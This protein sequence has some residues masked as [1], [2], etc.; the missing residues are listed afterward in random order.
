LRN[1][2]RVARPRIISLLLAL[3]TLVIYLPAGQHYFIGFDDPD[4]VTENRVVQTGLSGR[5]LEWA[6]TTFHASNWH[7]V[8]WLS[9]MLDC[10][11]FGLN[12]GAHHI[13]S[14]LIHAVNAVLLFTLLLQL[15]G[16][17]WPAAVVAALFAWHPLRVESV[18]WVA[19]RKDVLSLCLGLLCLLAYTKHA[20][21]SSNASRTTD[22]G[23]RTTGFYWLALGFFALGL[24]AKPMLVTLPFVMMLLDWWPLRRVT[25]DRWQVTRNT[26][27]RLLL[28]KLPFFLLMVV[29]C[30]LTYLAQRSQ[31]VVAL[32]NFPLPL[33][34]ENALVSYGGYLLKT[35]WPVNLAII[36]PLPKEIALIKVVVDG[37]ILAL[38]TFLA[39]QWR[40]QKP[41]LLV[42]WLW[43]LGTLVPVIGIVQVG[44]QAMADRYTYLPQIG[45]LIA[46]VFELS[47]WAERS[48]T[49]KRAVTGLVVVASLAC[50]AATA[51]QLSFWLNSET[52]FTH[53]LAVTRDNPVALINL[54]V[55]LEQQGRLGEARTQYETAARLD[56]NRVQTQI[57]LANVM[58]EMGETQAALEHYRMALLLRPN[59]ALAHLNLGSALVKLGRFDEAKLQYETA[60][61][62]L[63][64]DPRPLYLMGKASLRQGRSQEA[65]RQFS[66]ALQL[67][68]NHLQTL[69]WL[70]RTR[71]GDDD[72]WARD[73]VEAVNLAERAAT[74]SGGNDPFVLDTLA[75]A[76][77]E[78][79][80]FNDAQQ[81]IQS[82]LNLLA[83][84]GNTNTAELV[85]RQKLYQAGQP[86]RESFTNAPGINPAQ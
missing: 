65:G 73:G 1:K 63:P 19:E 41:H 59:E 57:N 39:W 46:V 34:L 70:A 16:K 2:E 31:A 8:T 83:A 82:A 86:Y 56:P 45:L 35:I 40:K 43:F 20:R 66:R 28:E 64:S 32:E 84:A 4:Y 11:L 72:P 52:L 75:M 25:S 18:A 74:L 15:T 21:K 26:W 33:R 76:Y 29:S 38:I 62:L 55:A 13:V 24:M 27:R 44:G 7:P 10:E 49:R 50:L 30:I 80:R 61:R 5:G 14:A 60:Q 67:D 48:V 36:Y 17:L 12:P 6:F 79:G 77:A 3:V 42:G 68:G 47:S 71:A 9:H 58:D 22:H 69:V 37:I 51:R 85:D 78:A 53:T 23:P 54:G 81:T